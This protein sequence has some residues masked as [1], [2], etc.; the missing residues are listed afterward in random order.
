MLEP[1][2]YRAVAQPGYALRKTRSDKPYVGIVFR[3]TRGERAGE[4]VEWSGWLSEKAA[5]GTMRSLRACGWQGDDVSDLGNLDHEVEIVVDNEEY[6]GKIRARVKWVNS[7]RLE[8]AAEEAK[9]ISARLRAIAASVP[10]NGAVPSSSPFADP[11]E[12]GD[13]FP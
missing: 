3:V 13:P 10:S 2:K 6:D 1:G 7:P 8:L 11:P 12:D 5:R 9:E 4:I